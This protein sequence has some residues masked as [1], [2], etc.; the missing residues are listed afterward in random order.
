V[1]ATREATAIDEFLTAAFRG[2]VTCDRAKMYWRIGRLQWCWAHLKR[3][4][5]ASIDS[6]DNQAKRL[7]HDL[8]RMEEEAKTMAAREGKRV[9]NTENPYKGAEFLA[10]V[11]RRLFLERFVTAIPEPDV[12]EDLW[13]TDSERRTFF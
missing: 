13:V 1:R 5:Q 9:D 4:F 8:R 3:D 7:G 12:G 11:K 10:E 2:I 6:G